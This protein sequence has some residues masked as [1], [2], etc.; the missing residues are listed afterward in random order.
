[1]ATE[2]GS[3]SGSKLSDLDSSLSDDSILGVA[4]TVYENGQERVERVLVSAQEVDR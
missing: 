1:M 3:L 4:V 2:S